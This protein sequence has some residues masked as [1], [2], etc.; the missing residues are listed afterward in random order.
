MLLYV[1]PTELLI[2]LITVNFYKYPATLWLN[3]VSFKKMELR[4]SILF[5]ER[6]NE[7]VFKLHR[8]GICFINRVQVKRIPL[9]S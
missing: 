5:I 4:R 2:Y 8:S 7:T 6:K 9:H 3:L 1:T